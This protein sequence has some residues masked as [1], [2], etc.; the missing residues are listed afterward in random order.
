MVE[1]KDNQ[2]DFGTLKTNLTRG[3]FINGEDL[4]FGALGFVTRRGGSSRC[5]WCGNG[6]TL[7]QLTPGSIKSPKLVNRKPLPLR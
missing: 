4:L 7:L 1:N 6:T 3:G 2:M 5:C